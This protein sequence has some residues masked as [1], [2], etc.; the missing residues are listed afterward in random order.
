MI[1]LNGG[2]LFA[3]VCMVTYSFD[4]YGQLVFSENFTGVDGALSGSDDLGGVYWETDCPDC[5]DGGDFFKVDGGKLKG[6][7]TNGPAT[8]TTEEIDI[9]DCDFIEIQ[10]DLS[11]EGDLEACGTGCNSVDFVQ[12]EYSIDGGA[13]TNP[14]DAVFCAGDCAGVMVIQSDDIPG[15]SRI[16]ATG[17]MA[18]GSEIRLRITIQ[19]WAASERWII[20]NVQVSCAT[21]PEIDAG[22]DLIVCVGTA[23][24]LVADNPEG[25]ALTWD[26]G[27]VDGV[28]FTP[29][30]G[31]ED[32]VVTA[33]DGICTA[34]DLVVIEV[35][36][37]VSV[38]VSPAGPFS[39]SGGVE[40]LVASPLS[41]EWSADCG[42][43]IDTE[44]GE[45]DPGTAGV[46]FWEICYHAGTAPCDDSDCI[47]IEVTE[48]CL[49]EGVI[50]TIQPTCFGFADGSVSIVVTETTGAVTYTISNSAGDIVNMDNDNAAFDLSEGWYYFLIE[51]EFP[52]T[53]I[54]SVFLENPPFLDGTI[55]AHAPFCLNDAPYEIGA[56][57]IG[58]I[59]GPGVL[60]GVFYPAIAGVGSH[61]IS[62]TLAGPCGSV[63]T[64][65]FSVNS[66]PVV[67]FMGNQLGG[68]SP[69]TVNYTNTGDAG[70]SCEW[71]FGDG[72]E[73]LSCGSVTH[74]YYEGGVF[75]VSLRLTD[76]N[77]CTNIVSYV[78][79]IAV[80]PSPIADFNYQPNAITTFNT[81]VDFE[82]RSINA[83]EWAWDFG[84]LSS[85][86]D[87]NPQFLF[88]Q[89][90][91]D[92][93]VKLIVINDAGCADSIVKILPITDPVLVYIPNAFTPDGDNLNTEFKPYFNAID[94][95]DYQLSIYNRW[96]EVVFQSYNVDVGWN[97]MYGDQLA[98]DGVYIYHIITKETSTDRKLEFHGHIT[99]L[100]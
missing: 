9:S 33:T 51:D 72:M 81:E 60:D 14:P 47:S 77:G 13:W 44:T 50:S 85:S 21:G 38:S 17:C 80:T 10:F 29:A 35:V 63:S 37:P 36:E 100:R 67:S 76:A 48:D 22:E 64:I 20:D 88:P 3:V 91:G 66:L 32:Y 46:G 7:D 19:A 15:G 98:A 2:F 54:D 70:V 58:T 95:Y 65:M 55:N 89:E 94:I 56:V 75:D 59:D 71:N 4:A 62:N 8:W 57:T 53:Y 25:A 39:E 26:H 79:Y 90:V 28:A 24:T 52:C 45:F 99:L 92:Y 74:T 31:T 61:L 23:V 27:V 18:G 83:F 96:G 43:C 78:D 49:I 87:E 1:R 34:T 86:S 97:G 12:F 82:D 40:L 6:Q 41:G 68:C 16:Y 5:A 42:D 30:L 73:A 93:Q 84:G 69:L 11:E